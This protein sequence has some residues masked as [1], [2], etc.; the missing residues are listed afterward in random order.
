MSLNVVLTADKCNFQNHFSDPMIL[1]KNGQIA[2]P[3]AG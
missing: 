3:K 2:L 1:P